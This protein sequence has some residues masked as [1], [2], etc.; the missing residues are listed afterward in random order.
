M[1]SK[2]RE[3]GR[4]I[5]HAGEFDKYDN[6]LLTSFVLRLV[7]MSEIENVTW[8]PIWIY[9]DDDHDDDDDDDDDDVGG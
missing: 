7:Y 6:G 2:G 9:D 3:R 4:H 5:D 1:R 8:P